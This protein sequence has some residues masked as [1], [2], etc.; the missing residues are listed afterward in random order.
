MLPL[1]SVRRS[2]I[3][4]R[5][6][7]LSLYTFRPTSFEDRQ[8][9]L[10]DEVSDAAAGAAVVAR[11][12]V[13][14]G[15]CANATLASIAEA[16]RPT[17]AYLVNISGSP[18]FR[19]RMEKTRHF[20]KC[21]TRFAWNTCAALRSKAAPV[22]RHA[23][24]SMQLRFLCAIA[25]VEILVGTERRRALQLLIVDVEFVGFELRVVAKPS[26]GSGIRLAPMPRNPPKLRIA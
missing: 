5:L 24:I 23:V 17:T 18:H 14:E 10:N 1:L 22:R 7:L 12:V 2:L 3:D 11:S 20:H 4:P 15:L 26:H 25:P 16:A 8:L 13:A 6:S 19:K 9:P 21:S